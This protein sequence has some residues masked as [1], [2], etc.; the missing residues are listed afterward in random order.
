MKPQRLSQIFRKAAAA[1][2]LTTVIGGAVAC[3]STNNGAPSK[4]A[5]LTS[6]I[7]RA[8]SVPGAQ[9]VSPLA[10]AY[11]H[12]DYEHGHPLLDA[13]RN[14]F[15][16]VE[17]DI[18]LKDGKLLVGH[19]EDSLSLARTLQSLYLDPLEKT[20]AANGG[21]VYASSRTPL[22]LMIDIKSEGDATYP[23]LA[24]VL[25]QY[26]KMLTPY[27][28][29]TATARAVTVVISGNQP[30][31]ATIM[32]QPVRYALNTDSV[33]DI[34]NDLNTGA[35]VSPLVS[36]RWTDYFSWNGTGEMPAAERARLDKIVKTAHARGQKLRF[37]CTADNDSPARAAVWAALAS[38]GVD[39]IST[40]HLVDLRKWL[41]SRSGKAALAAGARLRP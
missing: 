8:D 40:D 7:S 13:L 2:L 25:Q 39:Y 15:S 34:E 23:A 24:A 5:C 1:A 14:G 38:A 28:Q 31:R 22:L 35:P 12:N 19:T 4:P 32:R 10:E 18:W 30:Q 37:W 11:A 26:K 6:A 20:V 3:A 36:D 17:A 29:G 21:S 27:A 9:P 16:A 41:Q 33:R